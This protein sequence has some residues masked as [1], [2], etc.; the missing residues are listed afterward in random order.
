MN[1]IRNIDMSHIPNK[2]SLEKIVQEYTRI[3]NSAWYKFSKNANIT[4]YS[5][6]WWNK[7]SNANLSRYQFSK[8]LKD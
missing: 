2:K 7:K 5:K 3:S 1:A 8:S 6:A 4:K